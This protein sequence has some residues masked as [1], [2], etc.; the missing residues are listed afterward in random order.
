MNT[1][2]N[3]SLTSYNSEL[4]NLSFLEKKVKLENTHIELN[5]WIL[6]QASWGASEIEER[7]KK[8][9]STGNS[10]WKGTLD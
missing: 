7:A 9:L 8:M 2:G 3:L 6:Q 1:F 10:I 5:R 4:S